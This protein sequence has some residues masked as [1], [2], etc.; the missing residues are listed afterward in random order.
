[1]LRIGFAIAMFGAA[2]WVIHHELQGH[3]LTEIGKALR[4]TKPAAIFWSIVA[5]VVSYVGLA[6]SEWWAIRLIGRR[7]DSLRLLAVTIASY[8]TSNTLG[9]SLATG[10]AVRFRFFTHWG[11]RRADVA[12]I[13]F[14]GGLAVT[15]SGV[16]AAGLAMLISPELP[17]W[18]YWLAV[19]LLAPA[20]M[21]VVPP[22]ANLP[23][24]KSYELT[25]LSLPAGLAA[26]F[27]AI[28]DWVFSGLALFVLLPN[29]ELAHLAPFLAVFIVGSLVSAASGVP[30]GI[31]VFEAVVLTL[32][33]HFAMGP[34][35]AA[36]LVL[37]R[38]IYA[39]GPFIASAIGMALH[40]AHYS[41]DARRIGRDQ[42]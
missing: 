5:T 10:G 4:R 39:V 31:G 15:V 38:V 12:A 34:E 2:A 42:S 14:L 16:V 6:A 27:G 37:Y 41:V 8:A 13:T 1:L 3:S 25:A 11:F 36:A 20:A 35:T 18:M 23:F 29:P 33:K 19:A 28:V 17:H 32:S 30:G 24:F 22:P 9:F 40:Q 7:L 21:W 26:L